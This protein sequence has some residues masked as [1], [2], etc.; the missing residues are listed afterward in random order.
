MGDNVIAGLGSLAGGYV[1]AMN[2]QRQLAIEEEYKKGLLDINKAHSKLYEAQVEQA[3]REGKIIDWALGEAQKQG[4]QRLP[5]GAAP[6]APMGG[7]PPGNFGPPPGAPGGPMAQPQ[8]MQQMQIPPGREQVAQMIVQEAMRQGV[9]PQLALKIANQ[10]SGYRMIPGR[11]DE[12]GVFQLRPGTAAEMGVNPRD[13]ADNIK[14]G[15]GYIRKNLGLFPGDVSKAIAAFNA[16]PGN[17]QKRGIIN[18][19]YVR[20]INYQ[21]EGTFPQQV[22]QTQFAQAQ[23]GGGMQSHPGGYPG[24]GGGGITPDAILMGVLKKKFGFERE[25]EV[26]V[27]KAP[28]GGYDLF[29]KK[30]GKYLGHQPP[31]AQVGEYKEVY[32]PTTGRMVLQ[33]VPKHPVIGGGAAPGGMPYAPGMQPPGGG[34]TAGGMVTKPSPYEE[35]KPLS[36]AEEKEFRQTEDSL[37]HITAMLDYAKNPANKNAFGTWAAN[38]HKLYQDPESI[39]KGVVRGALEFGGMKPPTSSESKFLAMLE[40]FNSAIRYNLYAGNLTPQEAE[41]YMKQAA[42]S[43]TPEQFI[44]VG[45]MLED[46]IKEKLKSLRESGTMPPA[47]TIT[48]PTPELDALQK[49]GPIKIKPDWV[50]DPKSGQWKKP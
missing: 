48:R 15:V 35:R 14:G 42:A 9:D 16:G 23:G 1:E 32:D 28:D 12:Y 26:I 38:K 27:Q 22:A 45:E 24:M 17:I 25:D 30:G 36:G 10:E 49:K 50:F 4:A 11:L 8:A 3:A 5:A 40:K 19:Q 34:A 31:S 2:K 29:Q 13:L 18:P 21:G 47:Y 33:V 20:A 43:T 41:R 6:G 44:A 37:K 7:M 46:T 39:T